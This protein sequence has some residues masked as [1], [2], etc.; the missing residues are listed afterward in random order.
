MKKF[1]AI[2]FVAMMAVGTVSCKEETPAEVAAS[3]VE[4][5]TKAGTETADAA[6]KAAAEAAEKAKAGN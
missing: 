4:D 3:A 1:I 5:I 2:L 6:A